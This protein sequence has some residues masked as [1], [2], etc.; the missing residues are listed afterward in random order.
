MSAGLPFRW[1]LLFAFGATTLVAVAVVAVVATRLVRDGFLRGDQQ[2][3]A[4]V[5][6]QA[7][8][9]IERRG[10]WATRRVAAAAESDAV[11][12]VSIAV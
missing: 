8:A 9:G 5:L 1:K 12:R 3:I 6:G 10:E 4:Q 7:R 11:T 2:R